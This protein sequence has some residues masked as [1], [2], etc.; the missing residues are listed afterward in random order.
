LA[1]FKYSERQLQT[2]VVNESLVSLMKF[3]IDRA[4]QLYRRGAE[5]ICWLADDGSRF[6]VAALAVLN[7]RVLKIIEQQRYNMFAHRPTL[8]P[9]QQL[10]SLSAA[11]RLARRMDDQPMPDVF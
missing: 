2:G 5:G 10:A 6:A 7:S 11:W 4:R 9:H 3:E 1:R 8:R